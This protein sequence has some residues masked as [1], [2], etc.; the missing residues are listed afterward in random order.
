VESFQEGNIS[1]GKA[2]VKLNSQE[3]QYCERNE[4]RGDQKEICAVFETSVGNTCIW[5]VIKEGEVRFLPFMLG[6]VQA[7]HLLGFFGSGSMS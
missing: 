7:R 3:M 2:A 5:C 6:F 1:D 4:K